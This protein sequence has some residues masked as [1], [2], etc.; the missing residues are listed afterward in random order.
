[1]LT[2]REELAGSK[3]ATDQIIAMIVFA[4]CCMISFFL[5]PAVSETIISIN[6]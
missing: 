3:I 2:Q 4:A 6:P 5:E 1:M